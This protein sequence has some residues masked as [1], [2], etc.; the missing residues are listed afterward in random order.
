MTIIT[1]HILHNSNNQYILYQ[2]DINIDNITYVHI[3][4][5]FTR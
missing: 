3:Y 1:I 2:F 4:P 5:L